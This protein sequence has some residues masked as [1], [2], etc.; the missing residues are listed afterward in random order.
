MWVV[1][2][3]LSS[4]RSMNLDV[5]Y[6][7]DGMGVEPVGKLAG[8]HMLCIKFCWQAVETHVVTDITAFWAICETSECFSL[9]KHLH[10]YHPV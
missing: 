5:Q 9:Q 10:V 3:R 1:V 8:R 2:E 7:Y 6:M 4:L